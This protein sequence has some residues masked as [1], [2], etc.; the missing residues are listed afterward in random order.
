[1]IKPL[2]NG[3]DDAAKAESRA[4]AA[5]VRDAILKLLH[6]FMPF[7]TEELWARTAN[8]EGRGEMLIVAP[9]PTPSADSSVDATGEINWIIDLVSGV[10]S[11]RS[12]MNVPA[13]AKIPLILKGASKETL[14]RLER[15]YDTVLTLARLSY[16]EEAEGIPHGSAQFVVG[17]VVAA[18]PL[19]DVIDLARERVRLEKELQRAEAEIAKIDAK[20]DN[21]DFIARAPEDVIDEQKERRAASAAAASRLREAAGRLAI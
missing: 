18:L 16:A 9:W 21:A 8:E 15:N 10:R 12:E 11:V 19:G 14:D 7:I 4:T 3:S 5:W 6:P 2:L 13:A 1:L 20:L 17:E